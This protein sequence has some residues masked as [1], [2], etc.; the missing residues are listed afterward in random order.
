MP[1]H[2]PLVQI[3]YRSFD[4]LLDQTCMKNISSTLLRTRYMIIIIFIFTLH[5]FK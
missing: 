2:W 1:I 4:L 3:R 5:R